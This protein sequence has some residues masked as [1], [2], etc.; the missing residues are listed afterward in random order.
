MAEILLY[1]IIGDTYDKLDAS[2]VT[3]A[4]RASTGPL[5][6]RINSPGGYVMEGLAIVEALRSYPGKVT[7]YIDGLAAS[8]ASVIAMVGTETIMAES[9]L[10]MIHKPWD[11]SIGNADDLRRDAAKLDRIEAQLVGIYAK[12]TGIATDE[13]SAMLAAETWFT[14]EEALAQGFV[15]SIAAPLKIAAMAKATGFGFRHVPDQLKMKEASVPDNPDTTTAAVALERTRISS[16][17]ALATKHRIPETLTQDLVTRGVDLG[18][19]SATILD[20]LA[21]EGDRAGIGHT[22]GSGAG[23]NH[24]TLDNPATYGEA[25]RDAL[26]AKISGKAATGPAAEFRSMSVVDMGRDFLARQGERDVIR[27]A[28]DRVINL[29]MRPSSGGGARAWGMGSLGGLHTT[30]DFPDLIGGAAEKFLVDRYK[31]QESKL[32][33]LARKRD[34][35]N[36]LMHYGVQVSGFGALDQVN[37]AGE[38]KNRSLSTRREGYK[39]DTFG[40]M[41]GVSRQMLVN[42]ALGALSDILTV[43]AAGAAE[44][45]ATILAALINANL[46]MSDGK[47]WFDP[48]HRNIATTG[49]AAPSI[50]T[51]DAGRLAMRSQKDLDGVGLIDANPK[52][53]VVP[54]SLQTAGETLVSTT[55]SPATAAEVNP[56]A[57]KLEVI[58]DP[59]LSNQ[60]AWFLFAD[61]DFT[62][63]LQYSYLDGQDTPF[64]DHQDGWRV[65]GVEYKIRLDFGAG[66]LDEKMVWKNPGA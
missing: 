44:T 31:V 50:A 16:I 42:D 63:A 10:M 45:E 54:A 41:F 4:I 22:H 53:L 32:K 13:L 18:Q 61:P 52:Y 49:K 11:S 3:T 66:V 33:M 60:T 58:A 12:R 9:A 5:S 24:T 1:G 29:A 6:V 2:T 43:M 26:V 46:L 38:F 27:M 39:I 23:S 7:I 55:V 65:D 15:T 56:F 51:L 17:M 21:A 57:G 14:P 35:P 40:G 37:E 62:P 64:L 30:S 47:P 19:A 8:M 34:R 28:P 20:H 59:R 48:A 25:I 36:F